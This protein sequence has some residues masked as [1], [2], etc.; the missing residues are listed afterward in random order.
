MY[1][2]AT[3]AGPL[4]GTSPASHRLI[5][6]PGSLPSRSRRPNSDWG[7]VDFLSVLCL[8]P[9]QSQ[10]PDFRNRRASRH[11]PGSTHRPG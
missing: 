6:L 8:R 9:G 4:T 7:E 1:S 10:E 3:L 5:S 11:S 2:T